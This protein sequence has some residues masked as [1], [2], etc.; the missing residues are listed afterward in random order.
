[1]GWRE[2]FGRWRPEL[3]AGLAP[4]GIGLQKPNHYRD[5]A[6]AAWANRRHPKYAWDVLT[7]GRVRRVRARRRR[8]PRLDHRRRPPLH[9]AAQAA[10]AQH[11][12][13]RST[14]RVL[15][16]VDA[17]RAR[18]RHRAPRPRP[19]RPPDAPPA[20]RARASRRIDVGRGARRARR[21]D[22]AAPAPTASRST[23]RAAA[24]PTRSYYVAGKAARAMGVASVD[25]AARVCHAPSTR[26]PQGD[27]RRGRHD[28]LVPGRASRAT[29]S[30]CGARTRPTTSRCS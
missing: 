6:K 15:A 11:R 12:R 23:S 5:M 27:D 25:S 24:S 4:N 13:R 9:D 10:R 18:D 14:P 17:L 19:A 3:W 26:R 16:D 29:S 21:R 8:L 7:Q 30:C 22:R 1:M 28:L 20:R 2:Q